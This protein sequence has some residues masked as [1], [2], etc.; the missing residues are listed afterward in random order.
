MRQVAPVAASPLHA[1]VFIKEG[2]VESLLDA[3]GLGAIELR[4][5]VINVLE[6]EKQLVGMSVGTTAELSAIVR[7]H[8]VDAPAYRLKGGQHFMVHQVHC[9]HP[10][11]TVTYW[12]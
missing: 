11:G 9:M 4:R 2:T 5:A 8:D 12:C 10:A 3:V 1:E 7:E 6:L